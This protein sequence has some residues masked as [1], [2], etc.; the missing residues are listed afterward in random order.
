MTKEIEWDGKKNAEGG[1]IR[2]LEASLNGESL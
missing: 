1:L 2:R